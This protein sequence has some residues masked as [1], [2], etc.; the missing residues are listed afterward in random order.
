[1]ANGPDLVSV[2]SPSGVRF[3]VARSAAPQFTSFLSD[4]EGSG[5]K[6]NQQN[7]GGYNPR[8]I[9]GTNTPSQHSFGLAID[10]NSDLNQRGATT[11]SNLPANTADLAAKHG[12]TWGGGWSGDTRDPMHFEI[13]QGAPVAPDPE[14]AAGMATLRQLTAPPSDPS[15]ADAVMA[16]LRG[17]G[18]PA[19][20]PELADG[21]ATLKALTAGA[22]PAPSYPA[23]KALGGAGDVPPDQQP[24]GWNLGGATAGPKPVAAA[25]G[26]VVSAGLQGLQEGWGPE[27]LNAGPLSPNAAVTNFLQDR[28]ILPP[29]DGGGSLMQ[30]INKLGLNTV[31]GAANDVLRGG[32]ALVRGYQGLA[33]QGGIETGQ[34]KL[35]RD[36]AA[37]P[38]AFPIGEVGSGLTWGGGFRMPEPAVRPNMLALPASVDRPYLSAEFAN[39][40]LAPG[41]TRAIE[42][43]RTDGPTPGMG[44]PSPGM[45]GPSA[46]MG[47]PAPSAAGAAP[48][49]AE[50]ATMTPAETKAYRRRSELEQARAP[51]ESGED[52]TTYVDGSKPTEAERAGV[53][54]ISQNEKLLR[55]RNPDAFTGPSGQLTLNSQARV[56]TYDDLA[57]DDVARQRVVADQAAQASKDEASIMR[58]ARPAT[59]EEVQPAFDDLKQTIN[60]ARNQQRDSVQKWLKP[61]LDKLQNPDG[62]LVSDPQALWGIHDDLREK[63]GLISS[64]PDLGYVGSELIAFKHSVDG[65]M[66]TVTDGKFQNFLDNWAGSAQKINEMELLQ[67]QRNVLTNKQGDIYPDKFN[68]FVTNLAQRRGQSGL[69]P[70]MDIQDST[71][72]TL[73]DINKDLKRAGNINLG[74]PTGSQTNLMG[75]LAEAGGLGAAH[76]GAMAIAGP[77]MG[78]VLL[79]GAVNV[80]K[81]VGGNYLLRK[82]TAK[83]LAPPKGGYRPLQ[84]P[85]Q[86]GP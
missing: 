12:L 33:T 53:A 56:K 84:N 34:P 76:I 69:D 67:K 55:E 17:G 7:S 23:T 45:G 48:T 52:L 21:M 24:A 18:A 62:S 41:A 68:R 78:N 86:P 22:K 32:N 80:G 19:G 64:K 59:Q 5:Y 65:V 16:R 31:T 51:A 83:A 77:G 81:R 58:T 20:D 85:L 25:A 42:A 82:H 63:L 75:A 79:Q 39:N 60:S 4:L 61:Y 72:Q 14:L 57:S 6:L 46:G 54:S 11:A 2:Q 43:A 35:G 71:M 15:S 47:G 29:A 74:A 1:V 49:P 36:L 3:T 8:N 26:R 13:A 73:L 28:G 9:A 44:G 30:E 50:L 70:S 66:N 38:E 27:P 10:V 37:L 40:P